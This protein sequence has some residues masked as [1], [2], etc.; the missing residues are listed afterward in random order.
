MLRTHN[1]A[2][3]II[4]LRIR[5][6]NALNIQGLL[7]VIYSWIQPTGDSMPN[8]AYAILITL[9]F[10]SAAATAHAQTVKEFQTSEGLVRISSV[11]TATVEESE[12]T[13]TDSTQAPA[14]VFSLDTLTEI[15]SLPFVDERFD[16]LVEVYFLDHRSG[17]EL[18][19][20][21]KISQF[22]D[23][24]AQHSDEYPGGTPDSRSVAVVRD[25][26]RE[27]SVHMRTPGTGGSK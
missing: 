10:G 4:N 6:A 16:P 21:A 9:L 7:Q 25:L 13:G 27:L 18:R 20:P 15:S 24:L 23:F 5:E 2:F 12:P 3:T 26:S 19:F 8:S 17:T 1:H 14:P 22:R 11:P